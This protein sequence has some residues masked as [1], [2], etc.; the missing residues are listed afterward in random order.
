MSSVADELQKRQAEKPDK[1][2]LAWWD[3]Q[4]QEVLSAYRGATHA[5]NLAQAEVADYN[6]QLREAL[7]RIQAMESDRELDRAKIGE[8]QAR[9]D[10]HAEFLTELKKA[11][12]TK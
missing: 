10:R 1:W 8:L 6:K 4:F 9:I 5:M 2:T 11:K 12:G 7:G 3:K